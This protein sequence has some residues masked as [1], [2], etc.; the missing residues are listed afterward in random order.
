METLLI[1]ISLL[2]VIISIIIIVKF[3]QIASDLRIIKELLKDQTSPSNP[4]AITDTDSELKIGSSIV[5]KKT[6]K[7]MKI[8]GIDEKTKKY[9]C[10]NTNGITTVSLNHDEILLFDDYI[11]NYHKK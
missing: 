3:F 8:I 1:I 5:E 6:E 2:V 7:Q 11:K 10:S 9:I 4:T